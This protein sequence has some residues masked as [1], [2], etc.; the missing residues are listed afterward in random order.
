MMGVV[1]WFV[2]KNFLSVRSFS[3]YTLLGLTVH[4]QMRAFDY[5]ETVKIAGAEQALVLGAIGVPLSMLANSVYKRYSES[6]DKE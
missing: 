6:R 2:Q 5:A 4:F 1:R 3:L